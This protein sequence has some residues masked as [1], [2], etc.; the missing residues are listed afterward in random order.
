MGITN[1]GVA[2]GLATLNSSGRI[3]AANAAQ[4]AAVADQAALTAVAAAGANPTKAEF[5][6]LLVDVT[7]ART[8]LNALLAAMRTA[9]LLAP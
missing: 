6:A 3:A 9:G 5:D 1:K 7:A 8:K 4:S 2:N